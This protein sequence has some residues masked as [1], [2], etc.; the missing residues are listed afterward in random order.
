MKYTDILKRNK[1]LAQEQIGEKYKVAVISNITIAQIKEVL[2]L[3]LRENGINADVTLA[4]YDAI[5]QESYRFSDFNAVVIFW[6]LIN[7]LDGLQNKIYLMSQDE[8]D[9]LANKVDSE[10]AIVLKNIK[11]VPLVI[12]NQFSADLFDFNFLKPGPL[13]ILSEN[14]NKALKTSMSSTQILLDIDSIFS[15]IGI[16]QCRDLRHFYSSKTVYTIEFFRKYSETVLPAFKAANGKS[17]KVLVL[18]CDNTLWGGIIGEDGEVGIQMSDAT[19]KGKIFK[20]VQTILLGMQKE[21][22]LLALCSKNNEEDVNRILNNHPDILISDNH[23]VSKKVNWKNKANNIIEMAKELNLGLDSFVFIDDSSFEVGLV[24]QELPSVEVFQVPYNLSQ[25]P[26][27]LKR[28]RMLFFS[29][30][31]TKEDNNKTEMYLQDRQRKEV[32]SSHDSIENYLASLGLSMTISWNKDISVARAAQMTQKT[33]QF[34]LTTRRY[35]ETDIIRMVDDP[36]Y[37][38]IV[39]SV[40]DHFGDYGV[41]GMSIIHVKNSIAIIDS[42]LMSCR[43]IGRNVEFAFFDQIVYKLLDKKVQIIIAS[44]IHTP[45][46]MQVEMF[47]DKLGFNCTKF[48][49]LKKEFT[50]KVENYKMNNIP[51]IKIN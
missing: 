4:D 17:K 38:I 47:Y 21:G 10:I 28:L 37:D 48:D 26:L 15:S 9:R 6:E 42:F 16:E 3:S 39:F 49:N 12:V 30:T 19:A 25:Y 46:N 11:N 36:E 18:D 8:I 35:T 29:L 27:F 24:R 45:K 41:T 23:I 32:Q 43:V 22:V 1:E 2:E 14:L 50:I 51:Y 31:K 33:N 7:L 5:V 34:N 13:Q 44:Y 40:S 20:E